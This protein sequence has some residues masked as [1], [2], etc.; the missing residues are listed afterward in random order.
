MRYLLD[1]NILLRLAQHNHPMHRE[2]RDGVRLLLRRNHALQ[3]VPQVMFEFWVVATR[4]IANN[5]LGL[6]AEDVR[7][8][9]EW[10]ESF[11]ELLP[12]TGAIYRE[13]LRLV[14]TY[15]VMGVGAHDARIVAAMKTHAVA[16]LITFN[17]D[18]F[19]RFNKTEI[20][21]ITP[22]ELLLNIA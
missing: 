21:V 1:T 9:L 6:V 12:D 14:H 3:V 22:A 16:H 7:R 15:S 10:A 5:G 18:D 8:K 11:F 13:W 2:A 19:K 4:P 17:A 20:T